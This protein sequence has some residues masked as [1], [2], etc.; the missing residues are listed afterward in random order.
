MAVT[1]Q[2][3]SVRVAHV[4]RAR[5]GPPRLALLARFERSGTD[6]E[7]LG[8]LRRS[9]S[10][11]HYRCTTAADA[12]AYQ[13]VQLNAPAVPA[14]EMNAALRWSVKDSLD[15]PVD[16][17]LIDSFDVP[18]DGS[19]MG[20]A[21]LVLTVAARRERIAARIQA[22]QRAGV[23]LS[24]I[25]IGE[26]AQRNLAALFEQPDRALAFLTFDQQG[27]LLTFTRNGEL[28]AQRRIDAT[29]KTLSS[30]APSQAR[31]QLF[32]RI[33]LELQ[34]SLDNFDRLFSQ[35]ALQRVLVGPFDGASSLVAYL[36]ANLAPPVEAADLAGVF[37]CDKGADLGGPVEQAE[38]LYPLGLAL[39]EPLTA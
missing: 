7:D 13:I 16:D 24:V 19:P 32:E 22:F 12:S 25:D 39:R 36:A 31:E 20:R 23:P 4:V 38:W 2:Q 1:L 10:L 18:V 37:A 21:R 34:R 11:Q 26:A 15:F 33:A 28:Y 17:A 3:G 27:G 8:K 30:S 35:L 29:T 6:A 14:A 5:T 9:L